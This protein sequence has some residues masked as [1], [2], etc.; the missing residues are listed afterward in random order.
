MHTATRVMPYITTGS[1]RLNRFC[2]CYCLKCT[3]R[4]VTRARLT[5]ATTA[6]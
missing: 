3:N 5:K 6:A 1:V 2:Y 4:A